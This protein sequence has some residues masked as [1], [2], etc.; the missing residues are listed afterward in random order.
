M[1]GVVGAA[2]VDGYGRAF[3]PLIVVVVV[4]EGRHGQPR[5]KLNWKCSETLI[6]IADKC[7]LKSPT[8][9][10]MPKREWRSDFELL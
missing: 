6:Y 8:N 10:L 5:A 4:A 9:Q 7:R 2:V 3:V 1:D